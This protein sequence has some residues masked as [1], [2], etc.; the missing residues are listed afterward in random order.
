MKIQQISTVLTGM[1]AA[2]FIGFSPVQA[3]DIYAG[4]N[5]YLRINELFPGTYSSVKPEGAGKTRAEVQAELAEANRTGDIYGSGE[6]FVKLN[7]VFPG[8]YPSVEPVAMGKTRAQVQAELTDAVRTG[9]AYSG[10]D[11]IDTLKVTFPGNYPPKSP[12]IAVTQAE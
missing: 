5:D 10:G 2:A 12:M 3:G 9:D 6:T 8:R 7:Q 1:A 4:G 11:N